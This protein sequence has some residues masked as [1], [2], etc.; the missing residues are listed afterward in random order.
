M[1]AVAIHGINDRKVASAPRYAEV[2]AKVLDTLRDRLLIAYNAQFD[3]RLLRQT[4]RQNG[5]WDIPNVWDCAME[6]Y[7]RYVGQW[8]SRRGSYAWLP[9]P[10][11]TAPT[12]Y[13]HQAID[14]CLATLD[15]IRRMAGD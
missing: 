13:K 6:H 2:H 4:A 14:D 5:L 9:L 1:D 7:A 8:N 10:R 3:R 15:V 11:P 12:G